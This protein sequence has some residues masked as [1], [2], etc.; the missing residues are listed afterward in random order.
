[1]QDLTPTLLLAKRA[2]TV[3]QP[4]ARRCVAISRDFVIESARPQDSG[5]IDEDAAE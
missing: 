3:R 1:V 5:R 4:P 2:V